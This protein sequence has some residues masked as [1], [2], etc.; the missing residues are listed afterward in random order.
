MGGTGLAPAEMNVI[1]CQHHSNQETGGKWTAPGARLL[2]Q[3]RLHLREGK[4][5]FNNVQKL[6]GHHPLPEALEPDGF[7]DEI[8]QI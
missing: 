8:D 5:G 4:R 1:T 6:Q 2:P 7:K 3:I